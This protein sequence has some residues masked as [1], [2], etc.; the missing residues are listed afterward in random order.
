MN[1]QGEELKNK[2]EEMIQTLS[3][4]R[5]RNQKIGNKDIRGLGPADRKRT[6][7]AIELICDPSILFLDEPT[8]GLDS[9]SANRLVQLITNQAKLGKT[10]VATI[11]QPNSSTFALFDKLLLLMDGYPI[12]QGDAQSAAEYFKNLGFVIPRFSN[13]ADYFLEEFFIPY[14]KEQKDV[15]K[16][17][18]LVDGY[19]QKIDEN[20]RK[21]N[22]MIIHEEITKEI[23]N[24]N[25]AKA[26]LFVEFGY[27][28]N[29]TFKNI[30][31]NPTS[32]RVRIYQTL[33]I[34]ILIILV[35]WDLGTSDA[36]IQNKAGFCF[37]LGIS[38]IF[39]PMQSVLLLFIT[40]RPVFLREYAAKS[41]GIIP[42]YI[43][44]TIVEIPFEIFFPILTSV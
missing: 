15:E 19:A 33:C 22:E 8:S 11:H 21:Q 9:F 5:Q 38:Q 29:R 7:I 42:Y 6:S 24:E 25:R 43:S 23:L 39:N 31:R 40:E 35:F 18:K 4:V 28:L 2:V 17:D 26:S 14:R 44:K 20:I 36:D 13:P 37:F 34:I 32:T 12:Y 27:L 3:L 16:L 1:Y 41:Y 10:M 30:H